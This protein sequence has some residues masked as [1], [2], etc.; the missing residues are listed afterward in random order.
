MQLVNNESNMSVQGYLK[1]LVS[2]LTETFSIIG[3]SILLLIYDYKSFLILS[4]FLLIIFSL[5]VL[6]TSKLLTD[7]GNQR[8]DLE[9]QK[10]KDIQQSF[11]RFKFVKLS[12]S[13]D[14]VANLFKNS[15][16]K[17]ASIRAKEFF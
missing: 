9:I 14:Y 15:N 12:N 6:T 7:I 2:I 8:T 10:L 13:L 5:A 17:V 3:I 16:S 1:P 4:S 11:F